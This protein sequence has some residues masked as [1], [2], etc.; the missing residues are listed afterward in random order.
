MRPFAPCFASPSLVSPVY[1]LMLLS[2]TRRVPT[3][4]PILLLRRGTSIRADERLSVRLEQ[5][6]FQHQG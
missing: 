3:W 5:I 1:L 4:M 6:D 2:N